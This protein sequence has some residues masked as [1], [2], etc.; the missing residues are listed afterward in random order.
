M[1]GGAFLVAS[2]GWRAIPSHPPCCYPR[3]RGNCAPLAPFLVQARSTPVASHTFT[4]I[5]YTFIIIQ[6]SWIFSLL[7]KRFLLKISPHFAHCFPPT[8]LFLGKW[9]LRR[10]WF[11]R[12]RMP[13]MSGPLGYYGNPRHHFHSFTTSHLTLLLSWSIR[14]LCIER[15]HG[16]A[17]NINQP[18]SKKHFP[19]T[20]LKFSLLVDLIEVSSLLLTPMIGSHHIPLTEAVKRKHWMNWFDRKQ[21][22]EWEGNYVEVA[23][24]RR[25]PNGSN[26]SGQC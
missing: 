3:S 18:N 26:V 22:W 23:K 25:R 11:N 19:C 21:R 2:V 6:L 15:S 12:R 8:S 10:K 16:L 24:E 1:A 14:K 13:L 9:L 4:R 20:C 7:P 5:I 17:M